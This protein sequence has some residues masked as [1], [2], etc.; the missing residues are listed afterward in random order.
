LRRIASTCNGLL[1]TG[2]VVSCSEGVLSDSSGVLFIK[3]CTTT[4]IAFYES[5]IAEH[6]DFAYFMPRYMG[7][8]Q[9]N[10]FP[11]PTAESAPSVVPM[12]AAMLND[13][14]LKGKALNTDL[15]IVLENLTLGFDRPNV[16][17]LKLGARLW[18]DDAPPAKRTK[19]DDVAGKTTSGT[20]GFRIAGMRVW[21]GAN[22]GGKR[23]MEY[24]EI[25]KDSNMRVYNKLYG[26]Q[27]NAESVVQ[28]FREFLL[29]DSAGVTLD[30]VLPI[31]ES[32]IKEIEE[33]QALLEKKES[34]I[35]SA[36]ILLVYEGDP[37]AFQRKLDKMQKAA[38]EAPENDNGDDGGDD[39]DNDNDNDNDD[40]DDNDEQDDKLYSIKLIDF[41]HAHWVPGNGP[42]ENM[43]HGVRSILSLLK[44]T[45]RILETA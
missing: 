36:S 32:F 22:P 44:R 8:L 27:F 17:D 3:P 35:Y 26:R 31:A 40:D 23:A 15:H 45:V 5:A 38:E 14:R 19:L 10:N 13:V 24:T 12:A 41:A 43:L 42:D 4:E 37:E 1:T 6:P 21:Q 25:E 9:L 29:P 7:K 33:I 28:G 30:H 2:L 18:D 39:N 11:T 20:L 16:L 34:R